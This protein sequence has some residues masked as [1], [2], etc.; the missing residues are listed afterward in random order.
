[1]YHHRRRARPPDPHE[2][3]EMDYSPASSAVP[4]EAAAQDASES[5]RTGRHAYTENATFT[6]EPMD[7]QSERF[8]TLNEANRDFY[9]DE[10]TNIRSEQHRRDYRNDT[11]T[12]GRRIGL[13]DAEL[14]RAVDLVLA[15][16]EGVM[17]NHGS[18]AVILAAL[19]LAANEGH[20]A[21]TTEPK[22]L[23]PE[24]ALAPAAGE[25]GSEMVQTYE[26]IR[27]DL[28]VDRETVRGARRH[29]RDFM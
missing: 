8:E 17:N 23:R 20:T 4:P 21:R 19:T 16:D 28:A 12:W 26:T 10:D 25:A 11:V 13:T 24:H 29:L 9:A 3:P 22:V 1:M 7:A 5:V 6:K 14:Q 27:T 15:A 2:T 18:A